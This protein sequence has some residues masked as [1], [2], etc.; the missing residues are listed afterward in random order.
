MRLSIPPVRP[1]LLPDPTR[2]V[3]GWTTFR[4]TVRDRGRCACWIC[5]EETPAREGR[6]MAAR[7]RG[8]AHDEGHQRITEQVRPRREG[9][10]PRPPVRKATWTAV[11]RP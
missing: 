6:R 7:L 4:H 10:R 8:Q 11:P 9:S 5:A 3:V 1:A 2:W